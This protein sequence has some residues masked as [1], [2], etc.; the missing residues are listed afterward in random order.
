MELT[1]AKYVPPLGSRPRHH[2]PAAEASGKTIIIMIQSFPIIR[3]NITLIY[4]SK[5][6]LINK[7]DIT[8]GMELDI[9]E[10]FQSRNMP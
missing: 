2:L 7:S 10:E 4:I 8:W 6:W 3:E 1:G 5:V 9:F